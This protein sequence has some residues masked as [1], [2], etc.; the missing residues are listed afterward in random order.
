MNI[1][2]TIVTSLETVSQF[3][4]IKPEK[5]HPGRLQIVDMHFITGH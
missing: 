4:M 3:L 1:S 2:E 5:M